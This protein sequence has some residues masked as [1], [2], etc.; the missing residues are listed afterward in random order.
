MR[1]ELVAQ[2]VKVARNAQ[3]RAIVYGPAAL[4]EQK[5]VVEHAE[6]Q[7]AGLMDDRGDGHAAVCYLQP[8]PAVALRARARSSF[9]KICKL[10]ADR[11]SCIAARGCRDGGKIEINA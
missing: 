5:E 7:V 3:L 4:S 11:T 8:R 2:G 6:H 1:W 9:K 10:N